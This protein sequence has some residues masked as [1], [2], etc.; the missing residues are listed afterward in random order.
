[1]AAQPAVHEDGPV[2]SRTVDVPVMEGGV[3][4]T[5]VPYT[6]SGKW[7]VHVEQAIP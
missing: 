2:G 1:L 5:E 7:M 3:G 6:S 4:G